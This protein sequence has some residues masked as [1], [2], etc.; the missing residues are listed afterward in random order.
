MSS[1]PRNNEYPE[2]LEAAAHPQDEWAER[3]ADDLRQI[4]AMSAGRWGVGVAITIDALNLCMQIRGNDTFL[5]LYDCPDQLK[6]FAQAGVDVNIRLVERQRAAIN[7]EYEGGVYD[8]F[9]AGWVPERAIPM[10]VDA[11]NL[12][13]ADVYAEFGLPYQQQLIDH[14]G[15][16]NMHVH[17]NGRHLLDHVAK[18]KGAIVALIAD[19]GSDIAAID[20]LEAIKTR[21][22]N[23]TPVVS[24]ER[25]QF[26]RKLNEESL[27]GGIYYRVDGLP[28]ID[29]ANRL[30]ESVRGYTV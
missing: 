16:S 11:Y 21:L 5:D 8:F 22:R 18:L 27:V 14:F 17:G 7:M 30:M 9:N 25:D 12:C 26:V 19:D 15:G 23:I 1:P 10:S 3:M 4:S 13:H 6:A 24:C 28:S 20:D 2:L 29:E